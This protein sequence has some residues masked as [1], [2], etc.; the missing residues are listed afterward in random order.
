M[1][2][3]RTRASMLDAPNASTKGTVKKNA[4]QSKLLMK[5]AAVIGDLQ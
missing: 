5:G 3:R 1:W 4:S 2:P